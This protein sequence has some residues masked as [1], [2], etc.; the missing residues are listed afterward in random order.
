MADQV[1]LEFL[2]AFVFARGVEERKVALGKLTPTSEEYFYY[3]LLSE[4][5]ANP[6]DASDEEKRLTAAM[7]KKYG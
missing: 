7:T 6:G 2:E 5:L 4:Q 1:K 3:A